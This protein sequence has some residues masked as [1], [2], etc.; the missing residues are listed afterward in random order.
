MPGILIIGLSY[1]KL[2][3]KKTSIIKG[4]IFGVAAALI[5][6]GV[7]S[8]QSILPRISLVCESKTGQILAANDGYSSITTCPKNYRQAL[9]IG[10]PGPVGPQGPKGDP[11]QPGVGLDLTKIY[12]KVD[13]PFTATKDIASTV[14]HGCNQGDLAIGGGIYSYSG[15]LAN[16]RTIKNTPRYTEPSDVMVTANGWDTTVINTVENGTFWTMTRCVDIQ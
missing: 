1:M 3:I 6:V 16:W 11:G 4:S 9:I 7:V 15:S 13:G 14:A 2:S 5:T 10:D 12:T 8:A